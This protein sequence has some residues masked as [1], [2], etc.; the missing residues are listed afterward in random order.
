MPIATRVGALATRVGQEIK[1]LK[2]RVTALEPKTPVAVFIGS[3]NSLPGA[4]Y[5]PYKLG[6][7]RGWVVKNYSISGGGF[8]QLTDRY[9]TLQ[10]ANAL[11]DASFN[12][13]DVKYFIIA[14]M[15]N[16]IRALSSVTSAATTILA[17]ARTNYPNARII[18]VPALW[19]QAALNRDLNRIAGIGQRTQEI[20]DVGRAHG[21]EV[22]P[23]SYVWHWDT[24]AW[25][26]PGEVHYT[27]AGHDRIVLFMERFLDRKSTDV[28]ILHK[29]L[30][31][32][33]ATNNSFFTLDVRRE[34]DQGTINGHFSCTTTMAA[35]TPIVADLDMGVRTFNDYQTTLLSVTGAGAVFPLHLF[36][37]GVLRTA[38][39]LP[40]GQYHV[41]ATYP[42]F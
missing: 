8:V 34:R 13:A 25:M 15:A 1:T 29:R 32:V 19:G 10:M 30:T 16:D 42:I 7:K 11:A 22:V 3:S 37:N 18:V 6:A 24:D 17:Q 35:Q 31:P 20:L 4:T 38:V 21:V 26:L 39:S 28:P 41:N 33:T 27:A 2:T 40:A 14:D 23:Y 5:W 12:K 9:F 36:R